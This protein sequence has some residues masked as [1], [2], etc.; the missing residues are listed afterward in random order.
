MYEQFIKRIHTLN[1]RD[2][3]R[4]KLLIEVV[5]LTLKRKKEMGL[6]DRIFKRKKKSVIAKGWN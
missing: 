4:S 2:E 1:H 3:L 6:I 5:K